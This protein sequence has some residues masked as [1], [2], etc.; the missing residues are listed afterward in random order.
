MF[1]KKSKEKD[2][3]VSETEDEMF[4]QKLLEDYMNDTDPNKYGGI[5]IKDLAAKL[6][7]D[8]NGI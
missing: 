2:K 8:L 3:G 1:F 6:G 7:I 5:G 4:C